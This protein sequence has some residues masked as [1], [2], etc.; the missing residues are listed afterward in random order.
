MLK[1]N[2]FSKTYAQMGLQ[3]PNSFGG[4]ANP[5]QRGMR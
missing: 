5:D 1:S 3:I 2:F 4:I